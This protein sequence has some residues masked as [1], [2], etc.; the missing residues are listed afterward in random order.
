MKKRIV[1]VVVT[2]IFMCTVL[3]PVPVCGTAIMP[4]WDNVSNITAY[5]NFVG[6]SGRVI[7][8]VT[9]DTGVT[10]ITVSIN[11]Y[12]KNTSGSWVEVE[13]NWDYN[14]SQQSLSVYESF[15]GV[16]GREYKIELTGTVTKNGCVENISASTTKVCP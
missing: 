7:A 5:I 4:R 9:G 12:Y 8:V 10:N 3:V 15:T 13:N 11:L 2:I 14:V 1:L 6:T 16:S